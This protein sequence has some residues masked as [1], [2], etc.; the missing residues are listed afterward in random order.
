MYVI[1]TLYTD[2]G[3]SNDNM[4]KITY[5]DN[6]YVQGNRPRELPRMG[7]RG[8]VQNQTNEHYCR[9]AYPEDIREYPQPRFDGAD[10]DFDMYRENVRR[11]AKNIKSRSV[12]QKT[13]KIP[14]WIIGAIAS[15]VGLFCL[16]SNVLRIDVVYLIRYN[17]S[18]IDFLLFKGSVLSAI[19]EV[20]PLKLTILSTAVFSVPL[21]LFMRFKEEVFDKAPLIIGLA[22][23]PA[24]T[25]IAM[26]ARL[27]DEM[28][29]FADV[30][31]GIGGFVQIACSA[32]LIVLC[33]IGRGVFA[34]RN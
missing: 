18:P 24:A 29:T 32:V 12:G 23:V 4:S 2:R 33:L 13:E 17:M 30:S 9:G 16:F 19:E 5:R 20:F 3:R 10:D 21:F 25:I 6:G 8:D 22:V 1:L 11:P 31:I 14:L 28:N 15:A 26:F 7:L 27:V 34:R